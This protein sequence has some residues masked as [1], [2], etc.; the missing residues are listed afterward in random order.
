MLNAWFDRIQ[1]KESTKVVTVNTLTTEL[2]N[3]FSLVDITSNYRTN[4]GVFERSN[5]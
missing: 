5:R 1:L 3:V 2:G 4:K